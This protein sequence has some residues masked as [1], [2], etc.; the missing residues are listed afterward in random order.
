MVPGPVST[1][2]NRGAWVFAHRASWFRLLP[3]RATC[4]VRC[5]GEN[6]IRRTV[7]LTSTGLGR[8]R[9]VEI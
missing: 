2:S 3:M 5:L 9:F 4:R 8:P 1:A 7:A 6:C